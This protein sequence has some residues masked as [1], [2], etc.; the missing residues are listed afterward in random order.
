MPVT[1]YSKEFRADLLVKFNEYIEELDTPLL[2]EFAV[3][4]DFDYQNMYN[5]PEFS[6]ALK[7]C[8]EKTKYN[9][10][11]TL[12]NAKSVVVSTS[13]MFLLKCMYGFRETT[14]IQVN[15]GDTK[16]ITINL[17]GK[18]LAELQDI[19]TK[20]LRQAKAGRVSKVRK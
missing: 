4:N 9:H 11:R 7:R 2:G 12:E 18:D 13:R 15:T 17:Q 5:W 8:V 20:Q 1:K 14:P 16:Q 6:Y 10:I 19:A 3:M